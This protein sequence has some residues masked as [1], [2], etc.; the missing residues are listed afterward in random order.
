MKKFKLDKNYDSLKKEGES[1]YWFTMKINKK[2]VHVEEGET[3][4]EAIERMFGEKKENLQDASYADIISDARKE[5]AD[6]AKEMQVTDRHL[7]KG[8]EYRQ[9][10]PYK[11]LT[12][13]DRINT[14][15]SEILS[16]DKDEEGFSETPE[17]ITRLYGEEF[18]GYKGQA[19][20]DKLLQEKRGHVKGAF[21]RDDIGD[22]D[23]LWGTETLGLQHIISHRESQGVNA[24]E[25]L[26]G[27]SEVVE[28]GEFARKN[29]NGTFEFWHNGKMAVISPEYHGNKITFLLTAYKRRKK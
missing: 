14:P 6:A 22:I 17:E 7:G 23:L 8:K 18:K 27:L 4:K 24:Y 12:K 16:N 10:T 2:P 25:F 11:E 15:Y 5:I 20:I 19:A 13:S 9:D 1:G 28:K 21:H 29:N 26:K 3:P